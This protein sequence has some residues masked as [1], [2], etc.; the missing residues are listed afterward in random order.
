MS[1]EILK[2]E[3]RELLQTVRLK[4]ANGTILEGS[5]IQAVRDCCAEIRNSDQNAAE[6]LFQFFNLADRITAKT[7]PIQIEFAV[8]VSPEK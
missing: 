1:E 8:T 3:L 4:R 7:F 2:I 5:G 6:E